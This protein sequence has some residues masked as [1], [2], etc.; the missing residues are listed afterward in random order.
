M[1]YN[2]H[3]QRRPRSRATRYGSFAMVASLA[4][5]IMAWA[6]AASGSAAPTATQDLVSR[7]V[8]APRIW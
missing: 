3:I 2:D 5:A 7:Q 1:S 8:E 4:L 6:P